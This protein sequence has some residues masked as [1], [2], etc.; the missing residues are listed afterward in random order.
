MLQTSWRTTTWMLAAALALPAL[1][2]AAGAGDENIPI[3]EPALLARLGYAPD[4]ADVYATPQAYQELSMDPAGRAA[5]QQ[6]LL[7]ERRS[8]RQAAPAE[9]LFGVATAGY[10]PIWASEFSPIKPSTQSRVTL[11]GYGLICDSGFPTFVAQ[12]H[13]VPHGAQL[14][15]VHVWYRDESSADGLQIWLTK[16]CQPD[17]GL[18]TPTTVLLGLVEP[19]GSPGHG[20]ESFPVDDDVDLQSCAYYLSVAFEDDIPLIECTEGQLLSLHKARVQWRR[21]VSPAPAV[22]TFDDVPTGHPF[23]QHIEALAASGIT[24]GCAD[25]SDYCPNAPLTR[26]QMAVYLSKALGLHWGSF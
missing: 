18:G 22:A 4:A 10:S 5:L 24:S 8:A 15:W 17:L 11:P 7:A 21:Q 23:F 13:D 14:E 3:T 20:F 1:A 9:G 16:A 25:G 19:S 6:A 26:G 2:T 12:L